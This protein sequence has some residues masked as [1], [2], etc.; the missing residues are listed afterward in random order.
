MFS[1]LDDNDKSKGGEVGLNISKN[2]SLIFI[3]ILFVSACSSA[4]RA[5]V[6]SE[7]M[8]GIELKLALDK[9]VYSLNEAVVVTVNITNHSNKRRDF[10]V[11]IPIDIEEGIAGVIVERQNAMMYKLLNPKEE[12]NMTNIIGRS[13][14]DFVHVQ[15]KP[16]ETIEQTFVWDQ[17]LI[18]QKSQETIQAEVGDYLIS[19]FILLDEIDEHLDYFEPNNQL[20]TKFA[21]S[22]E[23]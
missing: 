22:V 14:N 10:Y 15:L 11:P 20:I 6:V 1:K 18:N 2:L 3:I 13:H 23:S 4:E 19:I 16:K 7:K 21:F 8:Q 17:V 9:T 12:S 5:P